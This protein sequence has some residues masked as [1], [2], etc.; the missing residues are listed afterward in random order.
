MFTILVEPIDKKDLLITA[1]KRPIEEKIKQ[2]YIK[3]KE[4]N[5]N[6]F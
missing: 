4:K 2:K 1:W 3:T 5:K 6:V